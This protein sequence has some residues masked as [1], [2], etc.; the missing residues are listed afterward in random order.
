MKDLMREIVVLLKRVQNM[1][2]DNAAGILAK[3]ETEDQAK[4]LLNWLKTITL[5][6]TKTTQVIQ[7]TRELTTKN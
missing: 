3:L 2:K 5:E 6:E 4:N 7:K 1:D